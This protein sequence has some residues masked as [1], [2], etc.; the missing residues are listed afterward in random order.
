[1]RIVLDICGL[2]CRLVGKL[3]STSC[4][5][6]GH[7]SL[8]CALRAK[9]LPSHELLAVDKD[10]CLFS[11]GSSCIGGFLALKNRPFG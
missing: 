3:L 6:H 4:L 11:T 8:K 5:G 7:R 10:I 2:L 1:M 9:S